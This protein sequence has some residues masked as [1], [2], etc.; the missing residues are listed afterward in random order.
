MALVPGG[1]LALVSLLAACAPVAS[2]GKRMD[3]S[4]NVEVRKM[5]VYSFASLHAMGSGRLHDDARKLDQALAERLQAARTDAVVADVEALM[6]RHGLAV[7]I[8]VADSEGRERSTTLPDRDLLA[9]QLSEES[10]SGVTHR[11]VIVPLR[12]KLDHATGIAHGVLHWQV[13]AAGDSSPVAVGLMRYTA[14]ARGYPAR[15]MASSLVAK[16]HALGIR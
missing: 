2:V 8:R 5:Q 13:E 4:G 7:E 12:L 15:R 14:D 10:A 6:R 1:C 3:A 9:A 11:L 16:L